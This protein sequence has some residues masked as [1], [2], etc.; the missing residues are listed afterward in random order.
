MTKLAQRMQEIGWTFRK[1]VHDDD[2]LGDRDKDDYAIDT[3]DDTQFQWYSKNN[4]HH[5]WSVLEGNDIDV[6]IIEQKLVEEE[7]AVH[8]LEKAYDKTLTI[9]IE[10]EQE[11]E[12]TFRKYDGLEY[13]IHGR[14]GCITIS[15]QGKRVA[16]TSALTIDD[17]FKELEVVLDARPDYRKLLETLK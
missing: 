5:W 11:V 3:L 14:A 2:T 8:E 12:G 10:T 7:T 15:Y 17:A 1:I 13:Q 16:I 4:E 9:I 6:S